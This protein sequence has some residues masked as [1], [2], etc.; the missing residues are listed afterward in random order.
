MSAKNRRTHLKTAKAKAQRQKKI[1]IVLGAVFALVLVVQVPRMLKK[2]HA[3][4]PAAAVATSQSQTPTSAAAAAS[5]LNLTTAAS[6]SRLP[7]SDLPP[8]RTKSQLS[9]FEHFKSKDPFAQQVTEAVPGAQASAG[10]APTA[11]TSSPTAGTASSSSAVP[12]TAPVQPTQSSTPTAS[13]NRAVSTSS[14]KIAT[15]VIE[16]NG[17]PQTVD[18]SQSFP[19]ASPT[20]RLVSASGQA[21]TIGI[22]G[23][24]FASGSKT[25]TLQ[26]GKSLTLMNTSGGQRYELRLLSVR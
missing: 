24:S 19:Q 15:A 22:A 6:S 18:V 2:H 7:D 5:A 16:V 25:L 26:L 12:A 13:T 8:R 9:S 1:M 10:V 23:G 11:S 20:F 21:A 17:Q 3:P 4:S 14:Q